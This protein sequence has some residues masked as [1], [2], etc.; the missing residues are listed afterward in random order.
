MI[1]TWEE[2]EKELFTPEEIR[3]AEFKARFMDMVLKAYD[4]NM[5]ISRE[6]LVEIT[7]EFLDKLKI[8]EPALA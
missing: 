2:V 5:G 3:E 8:K 7:V 4:E 6:R 1:R